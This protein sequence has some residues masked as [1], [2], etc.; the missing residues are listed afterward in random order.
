MDDYDALPPRSVIWICDVPFNNNYKNVLTF[1]NRPQQNNYFFSKAKIKLEKYTYVRKD[2]SVVVNAK[3]EDVNICNYIVFTNRDNID[4]ENWIY[5]FII[6]CEYVSENSTR[7]YF[8]TDVFQTYQFEIEYRSSFVEREHVSDDYFGNY[9][10]NEEL[11]LGEYI[12]NNHY[13]DPSSRN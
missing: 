2:N 7:I 1:T 10:L 11:D 13:R 5:A 9:T 6:E 12:I 4:K 8:E 3:F